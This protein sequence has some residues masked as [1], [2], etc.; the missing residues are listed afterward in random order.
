MCECAHRTE[1]HPHK[2][3][4]EWKLFHFFSFVAFFCFSFYWRFIYELAALTE[5]IWIMNKFRLNI[6]FLF[7]YA[8]WFVQEVQ[9][10]YE[11][12][13]KNRDLW[14]ECHP[15][16]L[17]SLRFLNKLIMYD[18]YLYRRKRKK[19]NRLSNFFVVKQLLNQYFNIPL[20]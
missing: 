4:N 3:Q 8:L 10:E 14:A 18:F 1:T 7:I 12:N 20:K 17:K 13:V 9:R 15:N 19:R 11:R 6:V 16:R 5:S 2:K